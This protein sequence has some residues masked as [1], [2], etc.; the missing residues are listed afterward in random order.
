MFFLHF[1]AKMVAKASGF[2][3]FFNSRVMD[4]V[5]FQ[6][7]CDYWGISLTSS[8]NHEE[9]LLHSSGRY[10]KSTIVDNELRR[11]HHN[12][13]S[14]YNIRQRHILQLP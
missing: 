3:N 13:G 10:S 11:V 5:F 8:D 1:Y 9:Q 14:L 12:N 6:L 2:F 7:T 4:S